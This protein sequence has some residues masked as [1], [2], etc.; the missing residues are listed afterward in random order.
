MLVVAQISPGTVC[1]ILVHLFLFCLHNVIGICLIF[2]WR[3][4]SWFQNPL[5]PCVKLPDL[6]RIRYDDVP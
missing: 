2:G 3:I 4:R 1:L 5:G 6:F